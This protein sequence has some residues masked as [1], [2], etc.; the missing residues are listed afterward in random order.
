MT[1][2]DAT[3]ATL[4]RR[5]WVR[6]GED[7]T[8]PQRSLA[9]VVARH[10]RPGRAHRVE[11]HDAPVP[12]AF[13]VTAISVI[14]GTG[15]VVFVAV[16]QRRHDVDHAFFSQYWRTEHARFGHEIAGARGYIQLHADEGAPVDGVCL[17]T[18]DDEDVLR[19]GL[20]APVMSVDA[21]ADEERFVD[22]A[23]SYGMVCDLARAV[24]PA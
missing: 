14:P 3:L 18:F 20:A 22:H 19:S 24:A 15:P 16:L 4:P 8:V 7:A 23:L 5:L 1:S 17:V 12:G 9:T 13:G 2:G 21:R 6:L 10:P 11:L